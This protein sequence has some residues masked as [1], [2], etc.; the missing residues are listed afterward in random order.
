MEI[1]LNNLLNAC[2]IVPYDDDT[3]DRFINGY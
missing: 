2:I 1:A 3:I